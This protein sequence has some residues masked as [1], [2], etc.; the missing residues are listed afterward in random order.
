MK[1]PEVSN[2]TPFTNIAPQ[3][4]DTQAAPTT[5]SQ[6]GATPSVTHSTPYS[7]PTMAIDGSTG[8][9]IIEYR[10]STSGLE[11]SQIPSRAALEYEQSQRL[12]ASKPEENKG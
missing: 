9:I 5:S 4:K 11:E 12:T 6:Q 8:A 1:L 3:P 7:S 10:N 2:A